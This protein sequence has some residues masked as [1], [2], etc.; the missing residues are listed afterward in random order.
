MNI[1]EAL[2]VVL[3]ALEEEEGEAVGLELEAA[4]ARRSLRGGRLTLT[5]RF[6]HALEQ[7]LIN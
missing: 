4:V 3:E 1:M 2:E 5:C 7:P 6:T